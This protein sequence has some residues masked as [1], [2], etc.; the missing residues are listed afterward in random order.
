MTLPGGALR[1]LLPKGV[2]W[3]VVEAWDCHAWDANDQ[4]QL[5]AVAKKRAPQN[6]AQ[7]LMVSAIPLKSLYHSSTT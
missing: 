5:G 1:S 6:P 2:E 4:L 7:E 3:G